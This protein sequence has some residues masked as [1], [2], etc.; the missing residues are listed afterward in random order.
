MGSTMT[1]FSDAVY[2]RQE[3]NKF[4]EMEFSR[5]EL[6]ILILLDG[7][8]SVSDVAES[9]SAKPY[10]LM[11]AFANLVKKGLIQTEGDIIS[12]GDTDIVYS[13]AAS[14]PNEFTLSR[15]PAAL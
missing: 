4:G 9:L 10:A 5:R 6:K 2:H 3:L 15:M 14:R 7:E 13:D 11:P 8:K 12:A 1:K